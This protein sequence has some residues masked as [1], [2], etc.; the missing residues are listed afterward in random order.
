MKPPSGPEDGPTFAIGSK[1]PT[2]PKAASTRRRAPAPCPRRDHPARRPQPADCALVREGQGHVD[3]AVLGLV[4]CCCRDEESGSWD[5]RG[6][7]TSGEAG[8]AL[9][10]TTVA[11]AAEVAADWAAA[12]ALGEPAAAP[13]TYRCHDCNA[14]LSVGAAPAARPE[15]ECLAGDGHVL[16]WGAR[17][18]RLG[19]GGPEWT[20]LDAMSRR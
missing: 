14:V 6:V 19:G 16:R 18:V 12:R 8:I 4:V 13:S 2:A 17:A 15:I 20:E 9:D 3:V 1:P 7:A 11:R 10:P 5:A